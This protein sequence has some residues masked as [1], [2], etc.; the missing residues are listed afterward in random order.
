MP[1]DSDDAIARIGT[2]LISRSLPKKDW[3][4]AA[5]WA[6][7]FWLL[8][9]HGDAAMQQ[10]PDLIRAYNEA[11]GVANTDSGG[12]HETITQASLRAARAWLA[13]HTG[14]PLHAALTAFL[15]MGYADPQWL[16]T[17]WSKV[18]LFSVAARRSWVE[19][20]LQPL[21]FP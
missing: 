11:V 18:T 2:G 15:A 20:D 5:H 21:P 10:M 16:L 1:F 3:T 13:A 9:R 8:S 4:H 14:E 6:A 12:Y 7:A 17:H 19:P